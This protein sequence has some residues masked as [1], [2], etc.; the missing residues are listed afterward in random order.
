MTILLAAASLF[1]APP[2]EAL[3]AL[4]DPASHRLQRR[5]LPPVDAERSPFPEA[6][7]GMGWDI[8]SYRIS[9]HF[10]MEAQEVEGHADITA[11]RTTGEDFVLHARGPE[12]LSVQVDGADQAWSR[13]GDELYLG[14]LEG[15]EVQVSV[16]WL[17]VPSEGMG[18]LQWGPDVVFSFHE[19]EYARKWLVVYDV[20]SD[21]ASLEWEITVPAGLSVA[22]NG[23]LSGVSE[24][25]GEAT[26]S[27]VLDGPVPT[28]LMA[29]HVSDYVLL[30]SGDDIPVRA[31]VYPGSEQDAEETFASTPAILSHFSEIYGPYPWESYGNAM[32][33]FSGGMEHT[34]VTTFGDSLVGDDWGEQVNAHEIAHH[35]WGN[36]VTLGTWDDIWLNEGFASYSE[37]LWYE[38][39]H[40]EE[41]RVAYAEYQLESYLS[42]AEWE[43]GS[44]LY[45]PAFMWGGTVYDK[46]SLVMHTLR[47]VLGDGLFFE[48]LQ[49]YAAEFRYSNAVTED[50]AASFS[51]TAGEDLDWFF[52]G[53]V[54]SVGNPTYSYGLH[55]REV[56]PG[57]WQADI[58]VSQDL[59][60]FSMPLPFELVLADG[61]T[62]EESVWVA[63]EGGS[64]RLCLEQEAVEIEMDPGFWV[65]LAVFE[66]TGGSALEV[67]CERPP[68]EGRAGG[69]GCRSAGPGGL[70][71][72]ALGMLA[73]LRR[74]FPDTGE[75]QKG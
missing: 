59:E 33:P 16:D 37:V 2:P 70:A 56:E 69:C 35:W 32:A 46:G 47:G 58:Q 3:R 64:L 7:D 52:E 27:F 65:P 44:S 14:A 72:L 51:A 67:S 49:S 12:I 68:P 75:A 23:E 48:A 20:P 11:V 4:D 40:G 63:G 30:E 25:D 6:V 15:E 74:R 1:A 60:A 55:S 45:D 13:S 24:E 73:A 8:Q 5:H 66:D 22:A 43:F 62:V 34:T 54:Y 28:Y 36:S 19:P 71:A 38:N 41:G 53:W 17:A 9:L 39:L 21:K 26:W 10:D 42:W 18:G 61:S 29:V 31:W 50:M 57:L